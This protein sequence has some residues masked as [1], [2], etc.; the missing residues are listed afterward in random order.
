MIAV[1]D[2]PR[3]V[4]REGRYVVAPTLAV[5]GGYQPPIGDPVADDFSY[6][7]DS[8]DLWLGVDELRMMIEG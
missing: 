5:W 7:S 4:R 3:T 2:A 6:S 8:N 1:A